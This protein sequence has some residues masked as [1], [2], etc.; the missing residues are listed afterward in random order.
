MARA[1][2]RADAEFAAHC[3]V[4]GLRTVR[5]V[6]ALNAAYRPLIRQWHPDRHHGQA[7]HA[8]AVDRATA[9]NDAYAFLLEALE[10]ECEP[11]V[12]ARS[13]SRVARDGFPDPAVLEIFVKPSNVI[14]VGYNNNTFDL[15]VKYIGHRVYR[16]RAVPA[17]VVEALLNA[18]S[19][20]AYVSE[21]VDRQ[22]ESEACK[23]IT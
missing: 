13:R 15:F 10:R 17:S 22:Y 11:V 7:S 1:L 6:E 18:P 20:S 19:A 2:S 9:I 14:S 3:A 8:V 4:L 23:R 16:Y 21:H 12:T 5:T